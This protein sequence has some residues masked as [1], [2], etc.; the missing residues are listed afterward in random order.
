MAL[1]ALAA[2][3]HRGA[4]AADDRT[5]D[6]AGIAIPIS[7]RFGARMIA[8]AGLTDR[9]RG[10]VAVAMCFL[11]PEDA[12]AAA[13]LVEQRAT[14][15]GLSVAAWRDVPVAGELIGDRMVGETPVVRQAIVVG[16]RRLTGA[17]LCAAAGD[18]APGG[19]SRGADGRRSSPSALQQVVYKG[20]FVGDELGRFYDDLQAD[21]L[22][23]RYAVFHQRYSTNTFPSWRLAQPF[24]YLAH[25]GEINTVRSNREAMRGRRHALGGGRWAKRLAEI[26]PLVTEIGSDS[27]SLDDA[28]ELLL[29]GG[30]P[31]RRGHRLAHPR[32]RGPG[33]PD[34]GPGA[35]AVGAVGR[36]GG[37][38]L[39][40]RRDG[41]A[42]CST[43]TGCGRWP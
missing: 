42:R 15:E 34:A 2:L 43:A 39:R 1:E 16:D 41:S 24:G 28:L 14:A 8:E 9:P 31:D 12:E 30:M 26:G 22:D 5:G 3:A 40:R 33:R 7:A 35:G 10:R 6:G 21:D 25:N 36:P 38:G 19:G 37:A 23:A 17:G 20:L 29:L 11:P 4:R 27:Q 32:G 18:P 13:R